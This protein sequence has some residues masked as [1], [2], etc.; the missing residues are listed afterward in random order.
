[1]GGREVGSTVAVLTADLRTIVLSAVLEPGGSRIYYG[2]ACR[3][4]R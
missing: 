3:G 4:A 2:R 1:V